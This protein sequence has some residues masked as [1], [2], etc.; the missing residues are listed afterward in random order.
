MASAVSTEGQVA[1]LALGLVGQKQVIDNL[2]EK[3]VEARTAKQYFA[4]T[5]NEL[6][7]SWDWRFCRKTKALALSSETRAGWAYAY[8]APA[9]MLKPRFI[10]SGDRNPGAGD[11]IPF[12]WELNDANTGHLILTDQS[13]A[14]L[15]YTVE[16]ATVALWPALF[17]KAVAAQLAV[18]FAPS[19][20]VKPQLMPMLQQGAQ[21]ALRVAAAAE[22][23]AATRDPEP[24]SESVRIR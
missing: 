6:L 8:V 18:Y 13:Q 17:T 4:S 1:N 21:L 19:I 14:V 7:T 5:R 15:V 3:S 12:D 24:D 16:L 9:D 23:N 2:N 20:P 11:K 10:W 22:G